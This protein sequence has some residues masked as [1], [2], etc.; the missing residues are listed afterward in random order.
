[1]RKKI[2]STLNHTLSPSQLSELKE[3]VALLKEVDPALASALSNC[4]GDRKELEK[5]A[6]QLYRLIQDSDYQE[7]ILPVGSPAFLWVFASLCS[8]RHEEFTGYHG[9]LGWAP[10]QEEQKFCVRFAHSERK[11]VE[12]SLPDG[13]VEKKAVFEHQ[14]FF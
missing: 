4:P 10:D 8:H 5:L 3:P 2:L 1:M 7:V 9:G 14:F 13:T 11:S 6:Y 12:V